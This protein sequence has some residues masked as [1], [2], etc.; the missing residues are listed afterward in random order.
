MRIFFLAVPALLLAGTA[1][2]QDGR[3]GPLDP[4]AKVPPVEFRSTFA[5][6]RPFAD[7]EL[8]DW[9]KANEEVGAA[10]G[11]AGQPGQGAGR[12]A[13]KPEPGKPESDK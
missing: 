3:P 6:Y 7:Q 5:G 4:K 11:R 12:Q 13:S 2:A 9:R 10:G 8:A 1:V